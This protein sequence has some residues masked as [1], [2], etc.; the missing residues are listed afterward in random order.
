MED[1]LVR[2]AAVCEAQR[3]PV[4]VLF[5]TEDHQEG[6]RSFMEKREPVFKGC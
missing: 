5:Q 4:G 6:V 2:E 3:T 1:R